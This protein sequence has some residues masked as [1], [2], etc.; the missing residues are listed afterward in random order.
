MTHDGPFAVVTGANRGIGLHLAD[1]LH[2]RGYRVIAACRRPD[3]AGML[4]ALRPHLLVQLDVDDPASLARFA[5]EVAGH[6]E[7]VDLLVNNAAIGSSNGADSDGPLAELQPDALASVLRTNAIGPLMVAQ[8]LAPRLHDGS[9]VVN[10][11]S[12]EGSLALCGSPAYGYPMSKAALNM[13]TTVLAREMRPRGIAC[14]AVDPGWVRTD[15]GGPDAE[16]DP[17]AAATDLA[18]TLGRL[19]MADTG[20]FIDRLGR[21]QPW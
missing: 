7:R 16:L 4:Y 1:Q 19:G 13:A 17:V 18:L 9:V 5:D 2:V 8:A 14:V 3:D 10:I 11:S 21:P 6:C 20:T 12:S 15:M